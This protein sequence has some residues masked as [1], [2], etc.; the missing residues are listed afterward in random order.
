MIY[1]ITSII[2]LL[3]TSVVVQASDTLIFTALNSLYP[4]QSGVPQ[5]LKRPENLGIAG[6]QLAINESNKTGKFLNQ[7][8]ELH[9]TSLLN[10]G[11]E[12]ANVVLLNLN[13]EDTAQ[14]IEEQVPKHRDK[15]FIN[16]A[17]QSSKWR[18]TTCDQSLF[19]TIPSYAMQADA[20]GQWMLSK[21]YKTVLAIYGDTAQD[22][23]YLKAIQRTAKRFKLS[24]VEQKKWSGDFDLRRTAF[25]EIPAYT[26]T[27]TLYDVVFIADHLKT[28]GFS[29]PF[30]TH[31]SAPV[32]GDAG[33]YIGAWH[34]TIEQWGAR[35][36]QNRFA[37]T[38]NRP[39]KSI[40][41]AGYL[42]I[43]A[44]AYAAQVR[45]TTEIGQIAQTMRSDDFSLAAYKGRKLSF[46]AYNQ[47]LRMP[48]ALAHDQALLTNAPLKGFMHPT[49]E[50]DTLG[51]DKYESC[52]S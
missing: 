20:I 27:K 52:K 11:W 15:L 21:Q 29:V 9:Q 38:F 44:V 23:D 49:T 40:D 41:F 6:A 37:E 5:Y 45:Q 25:E 10:N 18:S 36:I 17:D 13:P 4:I 24:L 30:N 1:R 50:L 34:H 2:F 39:M 31:W 19:H 33:L 16:I 26:R 35:Q 7:T 51:I 14:F 32:V 8:F 46:R 48:I 28:F 12:K 22:N 47:Q 3:C 42:A 43:R